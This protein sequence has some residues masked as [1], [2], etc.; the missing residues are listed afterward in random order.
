VPTNTILALAVGTLRF[1]HPT[2]DS[3]RPGTALSKAWSRWGVRLAK[4]HPYRNRPISRDAPP[5]S[6]PPIR[7]TIWRRMPCG[8]TAGPTGTVRCIHRSLTVTS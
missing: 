5:L 1:A 4:A 7:P 2:S 3:S 8:A 6:A